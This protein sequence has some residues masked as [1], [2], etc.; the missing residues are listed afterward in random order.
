ME[1]PLSK[2]Q[3]TNKGKFRDFTEEED[4]ILKYELTSVDVGDGGEVNWDVVAMAVG[5]DCTVQDCQLRWAMLNNSSSMPPD[6]SWTDAMDTFLREGVQRYSTVGGVDW[7][8]VAAYIGFVRT[9]DQC[10]DRWARLSKPQGCNKHAPWSQDED[11]LLIEAM[12]MYCKPGQGPG[13]RGCPDWSSIAQHM[14]GRRTKKQCS[15]R[16]DTLKHKRGGVKATPWT[17]EEDE[18]LRVGVGLFEGQGKGG[19]VNWGKVAEHMSFTRS[20]QQCSHRWNNILKHR[21]PGLRTCP[22][23]EEENERLREGV[24]LFEREAVGGLV[25]W[26]KVAEHMG[27]GRTPRQCNTRWNVTLKHRKQE[28]VSSMWTDEEDAKLREGMELYRGTP[29]QCNTRWNVTLK[30]RKQEVVSSMWT[31]EEVYKI[32]YDYTVSSCAIV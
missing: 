31:D 23:T 14:Q 32:L 8:L 22:W 7:D 24:R 1:Q 6:S 16:W 17:Q 3:K 28:V 10:M 19:R 12:G 20:P 5:G 11:D 4:E 18:A 25:D 29:R 2:R 27:G 30:H 26:N 15:H 13:S 21:S 9:S